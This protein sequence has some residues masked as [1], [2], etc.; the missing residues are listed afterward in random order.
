MTQDYPRLE[1][2]D[3]LKNLLLFLVVSFNTMPLHYS[4]QIFAKYAQ[5][6]ITSFFYVLSGFVSMYNRTDGSHFANFTQIKHYWYRKFLQIYPLYVLS[7][8][9]TL[10][11]TY[12]T[13][14]KTEIT[15]ICTTLD[16][17]MLG[18]VF[19]CPGLTQESQ[20]HIWH[21]TVLAWIWALFPVIY[22]KM[23][24]FFR[25][26]TYIW[27]K[28]ALL[29]IIANA[30][31]LIKYLYP[32]LTALDKTPFTRIWE[33]F[34]GA[35]VAYTLEK[36][37]TPWL[38]A[39]SAIIIIGF[40][41]ASYFFL[42]N[43]PL[44]CDPDVFLRC[45]SVSI[46]D[47]WAK[48]AIFWAVFIHFT[49]C[50][51]RKPEHT[52]F[53]TGLYYRFFTDLNYFSLQLYV[54]HKPFWQFIDFVVDK[55]FVITWMCPPLLEIACVYWTC[56]LFRAHIQKTLIKILDAMCCCMLTPVVIVRDQQV[57]SLDSS[58]DALEMAV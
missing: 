40:Y 46:V 8:L 10:L 44:L 3:S 57:P 47:F 45:V 32:R 37:V 39:F 2:L 6:D 25:T 29:Y 28:I 24:T 15:Y 43:F 21:L 19:Y 5:P 58:N 23:H 56:Y 54:L 30:G 52:R 9:D 20:S 38:V 18:P 55:L 26:T 31:F 7:Y 48:G 17:F 11:Q 51:N 4:N 1:S 53:L 13:T 35:A 33:F 34:M 22:P 16:A 41:I 42:T 49:A 50:D 36:P 12:S 27:T 14:Q